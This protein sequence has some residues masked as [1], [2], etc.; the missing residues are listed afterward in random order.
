AVQG[1]RPMKASPHS[2]RIQPIRQAR[3]GTGSRSWLVDGKVDIDAC[4]EAA[5]G[6]G[7]GGC[8]DNA[9][10]RRSVHADSAG[11]R[12]NRTC[13]CRKQLTRW[14]LTIPTACMNA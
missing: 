4:Y 9:E 8:C 13:S 7:G 3:L 14:S 2:T 5:G 1:V 11:S 10:C 6:L 12:H